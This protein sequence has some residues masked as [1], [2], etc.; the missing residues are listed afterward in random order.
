[1]DFADYRS[2]DRLPR[3]L[4]TRVPAPMATKT[5]LPKEVP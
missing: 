5:H 4:A 1:M 3:T 2:S